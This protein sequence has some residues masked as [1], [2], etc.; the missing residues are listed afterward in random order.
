MWADGPRTQRR[1]F[2]PLLA[3]S[4]S[5]SPAVEAVLHTVTE[6]A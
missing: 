3:S 6:I 2:V 5:L 1:G 4:P